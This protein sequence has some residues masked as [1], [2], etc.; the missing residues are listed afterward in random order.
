MSQSNINKLLELWDLFSF[1]NYRG[2]SPFSS[3]KNMYDT[4]DAIEEGRLNL[5][6]GQNELID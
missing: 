4:I 1:A 6:L 3:Y 5:Y 2:S